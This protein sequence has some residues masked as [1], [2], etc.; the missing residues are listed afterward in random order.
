MQ[1]PN[2]LDV[3]KS[4]LDRMRLFCSDGPCLSLLAD[5]V[6]STFLFFQEIVDLTGDDLDMGTSACNDFGIIDLTESEETV[7]SSLRDGCVALDRKHSTPTSTQPLCPPNLLAIPVPENELDVSVSLWNT[8]CEQPLIK[9]E[10]L[11]QTYWQ[12][13]SSVSSCAEDSENSSSA[14]TYKS[15]MG[16]LGSPQLDSDVFSFSSS[17]S[18]SSE[19]KIFLDCVEEIPRSV[20]PEDNP[21]PQRSPPCQRHLPSP[22]SCHFPV[23]IPTSLAEA[24]RPWLQ[25]SHSA[26]SAIKGDLEESTKQ[27][28]IKVWMKTLQYFPGVPAHHPFLQNLVQAKDATQVIGG[29]RKG[30]LPEQD[31]GIWI[32]REEGS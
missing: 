19:H 1:A 3:C 11:M 22:L 27:A 18:N 2:R 14:T 12:D 28:D 6:I 17:A 21:N 10:A 7:V 20:P 29:K 16:S 23:S 15:D 13:S 32:L 8:K 25:A 24:D 4:K 5:A 26:P 30:Q 31:W 9:E